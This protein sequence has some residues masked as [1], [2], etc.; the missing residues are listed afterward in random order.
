MQYIGEIISIGVAFSWTLTAMASEVASKRLGVVVANVWR[1]LFAGLCSAALC[2]LLLG[3]ALPVYADARAWGWLLLSGV[4]GYFFGDWCLFNS[5]LWIGSRYGQLFMTLAP[6][7]SAFAAWISLGQNLSL[8]DLLAMAVTISGI[9]LSILNRGS[10][11]RVSMQLPWQGVLFGI[12]AGVGQGVG[13][14]LSKIGLDA[15]TAG[16]PS[17][18][19]PHI[20]NYLPFSANLIRCVAGFACFSAWML[21]RGQGR[22]FRA[23]FHNRRGMGMLGVAVIFGPFLGVGFSLLA[24]QH[25]AAGIASTLMATTPI[26]ILLPS[27]YFFHQKIT[28][29]SV[30]G[31]VISVMGASLFFL[32]V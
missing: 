31:A 5:Y 19:L 26:I 28:V 7:F 18:V 2:W 29:K 16:V 10:G 14:V 8:K 15:Y 4:V 17:G 12:G 30:L 3:N 24:V 27:W 22:A 21:L 23:G 13:L 9:A 11:H 25:V 32:S 6:V 20:A 1:M